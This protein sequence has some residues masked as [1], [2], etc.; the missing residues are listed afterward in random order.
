MGRLRR[1]LID[2]IL[3][4]RTSIFQA[5][6]AATAP[7]WMGLELTMSQ[8]KGL[9]TLAYHGPVTVSQVADALKIGLP[10]ASQLVDRLVQAG[11]AERDADPDDRRRILVHLSKRGQQLHD[12]LSQGPQQ[13]RFWLQRMSAEDLEALHR[14][15]VALARIAVGGNDDAAPAEEPPRRGLHVRSQ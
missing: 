11:L 1:E 12:R 14:G 5:V 7:A 3:K 6:S 9:R 10:T 8:M 13:F 15:Y 4:V 2:D